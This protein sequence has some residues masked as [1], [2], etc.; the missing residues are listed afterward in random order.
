VDLGAIYDKLKKEITDWTGGF[1]T[2]YD[3]GK[4]ILTNK[5]LLNGAEEC[6]FWYKKG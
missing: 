4:N 1:I 5:K 6:R 2:S 3:I